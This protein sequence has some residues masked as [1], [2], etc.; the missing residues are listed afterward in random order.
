[1]NQS[2]QLQFGCRIPS[3]ASLSISSP[4]RKL[5]YY[6]IGLS[7]VCSSLF[8]ENIF[9]NQILG[10]PHLYICI[11]P[12]KTWFKCH[13]LCIDLHMHMHNPQYHI[14][15]SHFNCHT[16]SWLGTLH[17]T[18]A[19][20]FVSGGKYV[21]SRAIVIVGKHSRAYESRTFE[22]EISLT[23]ATIWL[24]GKVWQNCGLCRGQKY[25]HVISC[26]PKTFYLWRI[27]NIIHG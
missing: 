15:L 21:F 17:F 18:V 7:V 1:M 20:D 12:S 5:S 6:G 11:N 23:S 8:A 22:A 13:K 24:N 19:F 10:W 2:R 25:K 14:P 4:N 26:E 3:G 16:E 9:I 27:K